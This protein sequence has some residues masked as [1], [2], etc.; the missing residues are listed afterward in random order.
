KWGA[1]PRQTAATGHYLWSIWFHL[2]DPTWMRLV[3]GAVLVIMFSFAVGFCTRITSVLS[4]L[5]VVWHIPPAPPPL[6]RVD[7]MMVVIT[8]YVAIGPSGAALSLDRLL[9]RYR[10]KRMAREPEESK[11]FGGPEPSVSANLALRLI[12]VHF[13]IIYLAAGL[14]KLQGPAWWNGTAVW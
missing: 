1:N 12:Q 8:L 11:E 6:F 5:A 9:A 10:A 7:Q 3:H 4:W 2:T 14:S 13:C